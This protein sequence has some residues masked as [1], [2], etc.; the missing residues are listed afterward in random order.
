[1]VQGVPAAQVMS[2]ASQAAHHEDFAPYL[3]CG[4]PTEKPRCLFR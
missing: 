3:G 4:F 1:M 2:R